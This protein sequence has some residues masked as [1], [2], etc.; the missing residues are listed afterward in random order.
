MSVEVTRANIARMEVD[1]VVHAGSRTLP[2]IGS[3]DDSLLKAGG[4]GLREAC[5]KLGGCEVGEARVTPGHDLPAR[6]VIHTVGPVWKDGH[7]R[8]AELLE[9]CYSE[10]LRLAE[11][12]ACQSIA[13]PP[14]STGVFGFPRDRAA[15]IA[16]R[17]VSASLLRV[18]LVA[19]SP[20]TERH[21]REA[22]ARQR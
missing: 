16:L 3:P 14:I 6:Y 12:R 15:G 19:D 10:C 22:A 21:L 7:H 5:R 11:E 2:R 8:E 4:A 18:I 13:F 20:V 17:V 9:R 1:A